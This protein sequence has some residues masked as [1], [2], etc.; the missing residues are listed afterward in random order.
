MM[1][2]SKRSVERLAGALLVAGF[3]AFLGHFGTLITPGIGR[4]TFLF[5]FMYGILVLLSAVTL[6]VT[7][8]SHDET[9]ALL[10]A[11]GFAAHGLCIVLACALILAGL[12]FPEEFAGALE[13]T[14]DN[15]RMSAFVFLSLGLVPLGVLIAWSG[16]VPRWIGWLGVVGGIVGFLSNVPGLLDVDIGGLTSILFM[17]AVLSAF[18]FMLILGVRLVARETVEA[19]ESRA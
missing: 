19:T 17:S 13:L 7:F 1:M 15:I 18:G 10:G 3:L 2:I 14:A 8:R 9:L 16:A 6:Y 11:F 5:I 12:K 4:T